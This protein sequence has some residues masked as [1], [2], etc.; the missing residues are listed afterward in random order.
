MHNLT[1]TMP[2]LAEL[3]AGH[4][5]QLHHYLARRVGTQIADDLVA[6]A[7]LVF[8][9]KRGDYDPSRASAK[10]WLYGIATNLLRNHVR[11]EERRLRAWTKHGARSVPL[12]DV[13]TRAV[14][15]V[16]AQVLADQLADEVAALRPEERDV[17]LLTAWAD[18]SP[19]EI[20]E[21][22]GVAVATVRVRL[23]RARSRLRESARSYRPEAH[24]SHQ[25]G[26][27]NA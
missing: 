6:E 24:T 5:R 20:A 19:T 1:G 3:Y 26:D 13:G 10:S 8:W 23:F 25:E 21:A 7:F 2:P 22:T 9:E 4:A 27:G 17:L 11:T 18:L 12:D 14:E 15:T 16:D